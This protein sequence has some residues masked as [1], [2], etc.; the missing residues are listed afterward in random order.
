MDHVI[1]GMLMVVDIIHQQLT[2]KQQFNYKNLLIDVNFA[3]VFH[4]EYTIIIIHGAHIR[5]S[6]TLKAL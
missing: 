5:H 1:D 6:E 3:S 2:R 4:T